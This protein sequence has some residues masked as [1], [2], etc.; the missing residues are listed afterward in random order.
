MAGSFKGEK[1]GAAARRRRTVPHDTPGEVI[2]KAQLEPRRLKRP[3][4]KTI[5]RRFEVARVIHGDTGLAADMM[6]KEM[7]LETGQYFFQAALDW[8]RVVLKYGSIIPPTKE[9]TQL[10]AHAEQQVEKYLMMSMDCNYRAGS[11]FHPKQ[12]ALKT[13]EDLNKNQASVVRDLLD[14]VDERARNARVINPL[15]KVTG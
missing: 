8:K 3:R 7:M 2:Q 4:F 13:Q 10:T 9:S 11:F 6:P 12:L 5:E 14:M 15:K 1:R